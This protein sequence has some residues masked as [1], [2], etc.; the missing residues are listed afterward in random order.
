MREPRGAGQDQGKRTMYNCLNA[1]WR[2]NLSFLAA[3]FVALLFLGRAAIS[4]ACG[5]AL[6]ASRE[7]I[8]ICDLGVLEGGG[9]S[10]ANAVSEDGKTVVG[11]SNSSVGDRAFKWT[12]ADGIIDL[13]TLS[14]GSESH[15]RGVS[16]DGNVIVGSSDTRNGQR[17]FLWTERTGMVSLGDMEGDLSSSANAVSADG[18][19]VV[20]FIGD[21]RNR[22]AFRWSAETG[23]KRIGTEAFD[24][25]SAALGVSDDGAIFTDCTNILYF[26]T[27]LLT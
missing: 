20:G 15:A 22:S 2:T 13:G 16:S 17:A 25:N 23:M 7:G 3:F 19:I 24:S 18:S 14:G 5:E 4:E 6:G 11:V 26:I 21:G 10:F 27:K 12:E 1:I 8:I 9:T